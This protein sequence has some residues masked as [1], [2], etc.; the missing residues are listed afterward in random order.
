MQD[1]AKLR[2]AVEMQSNEMKRI[3]DVHIDYWKECSMFFSPVRGRFLLSDKNK[4][5]KKFH[6]IINNTGLRAL[7]TLVSGLMT[8]VTNPARPWFRLSTPDPSLRESYNVK[9]YLEEVER[10]M[11][12]VF[13]KSNLYN[14]LPQCYKELGLFG[15]ANLNIDEDFE[16]VIHCTNFTCGS[17]YIAQ[18]DKLEVDTTIRRLNKTPRQLVREFGLDK[19]SAPVKSLYEKHNTEGDVSITVAIMPNEDRDFGRAMDKENMPY[20][21]VVYEDDAPKDKVL[22]VS[23]YHEF[24]QATPRWEAVGEDVYSISPCMEA[25]GDNK[26]LQH[27]EKSKAKSLD[28]MNNPP[29][30]APASMKNTP[31]SALPGGITFEDSQSEGKGLRSLY[32]VRTPIGE[33]TNDIQ[34]VQRRISSAL[35]EDL[36]LMLA[37]DRRSGITAR[38]VEERH[39]EKLLML[40]NVLQQLNNEL[41]DPIIDRT[42]A[43]MARNN[44]LPTPPEELQGVTLKIE[45]ISVLHQAQ[46]AVALRAIERSYAFVSG[47]VGLYPEARHKFDSFQAIDEYGEYAGVPSKIIKTNDA[48]SQAQKAEQQQQAQAQAMEMMQQGAQ[49]AKDASQIDTE[50]L[51][52]LTGA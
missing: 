18:N 6:N 8:G 34:E 11:R 31:V 9:I 43:I 14:V 7:R 48:A 45:Y 12:Y 13:Q 24:P 41:L 30:V 10:R 40:G 36:F 32:E 3:H 29:L 42:F 1:Y 26:Q 49:T 38:E 33:L 25:L 51:Q 44:L 37:N 50:K 2:K 27:E 35:Y 17:Y 52:E 21:Q 4:D 39:E 16:K 15:T 5:F 46:N 23:G 20:I 19:V 28:K 22:A 47:L